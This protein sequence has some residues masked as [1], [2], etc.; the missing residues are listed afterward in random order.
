MLLSWSTLISFA[1]FIALNN[2]SL[3]VCLLTLLL[4]ARHTGDVTAQC[5]QVVTR[6]RE[7][8]RSLSCSSYPVTLPHLPYG[9][10]LY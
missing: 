6:A 8:A 4:H 1:G 9:Q 10:T 7:T 3:R 2:L 5:R